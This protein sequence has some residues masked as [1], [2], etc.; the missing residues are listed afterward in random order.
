MSVV[1]LN[2]NFIPAEE[3]AISPMD[4]GFLFGDGVYEV[5][6]VYQ[7]KL[8]RLK[9]HL[10]RL[11]RS[12]NET[13]IESPFTEKEWTNI[14]ERLI[15]KNGGG[16]LSVYLQVTRGV[17][18]KRDHVFPKERLEPTI[19]INTS[20]FENAFLDIDQVKGAKAITKQDTR[21]KRCDIKAITLLANILLRQEAYDQGAVEAILIQDG[22]AI[23]GAASNLFIVD[24][25]TIITP[26]KGHEILGGITRDLVLELALQEGIPSKEAS[27][28]LKD[29]FSADEVWITSSTKEIFPIVQIDDILLTNSQ[30]GPV[31]YKMISAYQNHKKR[32][33]AG[34]I[35]E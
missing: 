24:S 16:N 25:G 31:W 23:E 21:W 11:E 15:E 28:G 14:L 33:L 27:I 22:H 1:Y 3:A 17:V 9:A 19:F 13:R 26:P 7:G 18:A 2:G 35:S 12:L 10:E 8:F 32:L 34:E 30:P 6:P 5:I 29:L 4:R 20:A